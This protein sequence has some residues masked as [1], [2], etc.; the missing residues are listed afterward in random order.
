MTTTHAP[1]SSLGR[2]PLAACAALVLASLLGAG[3]VRLSGQN[4][5]APDAEVT[6]QRALRFEDRPDGSVVVIDAASGRVFDTVSGQAGFVRG[7]LRGLARERKRVGLGSEQP[8]LLLGRADGRLTLH[9]P[10]T[11]RLIDLDAFGPLN[12][13]AF[14]RMLDDSAGAAKPVATL[15][16]RKP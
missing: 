5:R 13:S 12:A 10:A 3:W 14:A 4:I 15:H 1:D 9:D 2:L 8:F 7:T 11:G 16:P 6:T